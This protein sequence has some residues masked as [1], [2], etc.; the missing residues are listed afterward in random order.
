MILAK[1]VGT[2]VSTNRNEQMTGNKLLIIRAMNAE[3][4]FSDKLE[5]AVDVIGAGCGE[6]VIVSRGGAARIP[7]GQRQVPVDLT[8]VE[9][10]DTMEV[11][12]E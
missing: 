5:V 7:F 1:V 11:S 10:V 6:T 4:M 3:K 12:D 8:I 9:I 2:V